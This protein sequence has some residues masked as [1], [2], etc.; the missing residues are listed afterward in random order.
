MT[1]FSGINHHDQ[2]ILA[3]ALLLIM[4]SMHKGDPASTTPLPPRR[5]RPP[6]VTPRS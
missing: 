6:K 3:A 5:G 1:P 4:E 2:A